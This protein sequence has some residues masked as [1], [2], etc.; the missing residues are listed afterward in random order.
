[1]TLSP[2][3]S[4][5]C[6]HPCHTHVTIHVTPMSPSMSH[7][8]HHPCHTHVT[9][10]VT[11]YKMWNELK[12]ACPVEW[13]ETMIVC[14][15][16]QFICSN[17]NCDS[18]QLEHKTLT[19]FNSF[20]KPRWLWRGRPPWSTVH[21]SLTSEEWFQ[22]YRDFQQSAKKQQKWVVGRCWKVVGSNPCMGNIFSRLG[23]LAG[24]NLGGVYIVI[25][26]GSDNITR[27]RHDL[28]N[29]CK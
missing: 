3:M 24:T 5:P 15:L 6:H 18:I 11:P 23:I 25:K 14:E 27:R 4:H 26:S 10:H 22:S 2:S 12:S 20:H 19:M 17:F 21:W 13:L 16:I 7:P 29:L 1:M 8:C 28:S 9:I